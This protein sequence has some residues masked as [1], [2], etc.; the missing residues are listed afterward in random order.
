[1]AVNK[2]TI[3][4]NHDTV[5]RR[6]ITDGPAAAYRGR[7]RYATLSMTMLLYALLNIF[8][9]R[10]NTGMWLQVQGPYHSGFL[11]PTLLSPLNIFQF[12]AYIPVTALVMS[13]LCTA[14]IIIA[15]FY[16][17]L[18][19]IP[20][21]LMVFF[22]GHNPVL[23]MCLFVSATAASFEPLRFKSKFVASVVCL[24]PVLLY[25][26]LF[27][28]GNPEQDILR[29]A[30][31]YSPWG[32]AF[33]FS[34]AIFGL[35]L[36]I[37]HFLRYRPGIELPVFGLLLAVTVLLFH[38]KIGM[39]QRDFQAEVYRFSPDQIE[40]FRNHSIT[41]ILQ[42][43]LARRLKESPYLSEELIMTQLRM[44]WR[45]AFNN[46][47]LIP[48]P[49]TGI[50]PVSLARQEK[51]R[52]EVARMEAITHHIDK[53]IAAHPQNRKVVDAIYYKAL[54][55]DMKVDARA[56]R[57]ED[58]LK[59]YY[60]IPSAH[61]ETTWQDI[62]NRF[63][64]TDVAIE[65]RWRLAW[66]QAS[67]K[68]A[69]ASDPYNYDE[70]LSL[71]SQARDLCDQA[72]QKRQPPA[73]EK[74]GWTHQLETIFS[75]PPSSLNYAQ[76][77]DL[78]QR[79]EILMLLISK[80]NR[81]GHLKNE[82][83]L[84]EFAGLDPHQLNYQDRLK[85]LMLNSPKPDP[86]QD[87]IELAQALLIKEPFE[88]AT[89]LA[90]ISQ[91]YAGRDGALGATLALAQLLSKK[92]LDEKQHEQVHE[93]LQAAIDKNPDSFLIQCAR[94]ILEKSASK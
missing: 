48:Q 8:V 42:Q 20:F 23:S 13:L 1:M 64:D 40:T 3:E 6:W 10:L 16:N 2:N 57:D 65:A 24:I 70:P 53:F 54:L 58:T 55:T 46:D 26:F 17:L 94:R 9:L 87:N 21:V 11:I 28:G 33:L 25:W 52:I 22:L 76:L 88:K 80:E 60:D 59:F 4:P 7:V 47:I 86:L 79:I 30:L 35:V 63:A 12:P 56:L 68:T 75:P 27:S 92:T 32:L 90:A 66:L 18:Y 34:V 19:A 77:Y 62:L 82:E 36:T 67:H 51:L 71:L 78:R 37:G 83:R 91:Q 14:P 93:L 29:W 85:E 38:F 89:R 61:C 44:E 74:S 69:K 50:S 5:A 81:T 43:E 72:L 84:A 39:N 31:L 15:Q 73:E 41:P 49:T 45:W